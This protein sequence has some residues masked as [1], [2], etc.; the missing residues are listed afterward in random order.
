MYTPYYNRIMTQLFNDDVWF[1][2][3]E[4]FRELEDIP[5]TTTTTYEELVLQLPEST[6]PHAKRL[7]D[8]FSNRETVGPSPN[9]HAFANYATFA[10]VMDDLFSY[11]S[12]ANYWQVS[13]DQ[14]LAYI[15][16]ELNELTN[17]PKADVDTLCLAIAA[18][19]NMFTRP[20][21][22]SFIQTFIQTT[23]TCV[24][25]FYNTKDDSWLVNYVI[26][27]A[28]ITHNL[29]LMWAIC[30]PKLPESVPNKY[31]IILAKYF[32]KYSNLDGLQYLGQRHPAIFGLMDV[33]TF[34]AN[35]GN[36]ACLEYAHRMGCPL[37]YSKLCAL[38]VGKECLQYLHLQGQK[39]ND[40]ALDTGL[41][42]VAIK[43]N[44]CEALHYII[45]EMGRQ[46]STPLLSDEMEMA[47][48]YGSLE[49]LQYLVEKH[50][51]VFQDKAVTL[52]ERVVEYK[53]THCLQYLLT[54][55]PFT[56]WSDSNPN[57]TLRKL[58]SL[59]A[60][61]GYVDILKCLCDK[62]PAT[63]YP[64]SRLVDTVCKTAAEHN[65]LACLKYLR[66]VEKFAWGSSTIL[67]VSSFDCFEYAYVNK[68]PGHDS[69]LVCEW[70]KSHGI[71]TENDDINQIWNE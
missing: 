35:C 56:L 55:Y 44:N 62:F 60:S 11:I 7:S 68:C 2:A 18:P 45:E 47:C 15:I 29:P 5:F 41:A 10:Q 4:L 30:I 33:T 22:G 70:A 65:Q 37:P 39:Q 3:G 28:A 52:F 17:W 69:L 53:R 57:N 32:I 20:T 43:R 16:P 38:N 58:C 9:A 49:C 50:R 34:A 59:A 23:Q 42:R 21:I 8:I 25:T 51:D 48:K 27:C 6:L 26:S 14:L 66:E 40:I 19:H 64:K 12:I 67:C 61:K 13:D 63:T 46:Q 1:A 31:W 24:K 71:S 36:V 54:L